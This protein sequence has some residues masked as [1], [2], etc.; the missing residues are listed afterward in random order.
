MWKDKAEIEP[1]KIY[2]IA[3]QYFIGVGKDGY[4]CF[5]DPSVQMITDLDSARSI[6]DVVFGALEQLGAQ[7]SVW[8]YSKGMPQLARTKSIGEQRRDQ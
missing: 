2:V 7:E 5:Q 4:T 1:S 8:D 6:Q 3:L